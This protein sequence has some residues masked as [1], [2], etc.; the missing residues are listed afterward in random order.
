MAE[1]DVTTLQAALDVIV[2]PTGDLPGAGGLGVTA[3]VLEDAAALGATDTVAELLAGLPADFTS[4]ASAARE[5]MLREVEAADPSRFRV[6][7]NLA[8]TAYY[9]HPRV[10]AAVEA[11][12]GY[13]AGPPQPRGYELEPFD[14][15]L[16]AKVR[17]MDPIWRR[18]P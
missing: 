5:T 12:T 2:P 8:Y 6:L 7:I 13:N 17:S 4:S 15:S 11:A 3:S 10:L 9:T 16:L 14:E 18:V 1:V